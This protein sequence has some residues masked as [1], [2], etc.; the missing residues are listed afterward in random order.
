MW[1]RPIRWF[2]HWWTWRFNSQRHCFQYYTPLRRTSR[3]SSI[4]C[5]SSNTFSYIDLRDS[6]WLEWYWTSIQ[7]RCVCSAHQRLSISVKQQRRELSVLPDDS[8]ENKEGQSPRRQASHECQSA[9]LEE[10]TAIW[11]SVILVH[12]WP[13]R[14]FIASITKFE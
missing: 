2:R 6:L 10:S 1:I 11:G 13:D 9:V 5:P 14:I 4:C 7:E 3:S 8:R 12:C